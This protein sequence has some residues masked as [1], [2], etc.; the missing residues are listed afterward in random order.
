MQPTCVR[1]GAV[2]ADVT[3]SLR[4]GRDEIQ[5]LSAPGCYVISTT[6]V[7]MAENIFTYQAIERARHRSHRNVRWLVLSNPISMFSYSL[8]FLA[9]QRCRESRRLNCVVCKYTL[10]THTNMAMV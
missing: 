3:P 7:V 8:D 4:L 6:N 2:A 10:E 5:W 1:F 9:I